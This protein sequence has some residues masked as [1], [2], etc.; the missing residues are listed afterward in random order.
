ME[1]S[2]EAQRVVGPRVFFVQIYIAKRF[3][4]HI[5]TLAREFGNHPM[6]RRAVELKRKVAEVVLRRFRI[7]LPY[8][9]GE[10]YDKDLETCEDVQI[11]INA[12]LAEKERLESK[13]IGE[14]SRGYQLIMSKGVGKPDPKKDA[15][16]E[17]FIA[18][19]VFV[20][21]IAEKARRGTKN[22][23]QAKNMAI[24]MWLKKYEKHRPSVARYEEIP[25]LI[26][27]EKI[28]FEKASEPLI[29]R[30]SFATIKL[31][32]TET[33]A[34][35]RAA[36]D[37]L[38]EETIAKVKK[39]LVETLQLPINALLADYIEELERTP[40]KPKGLVA[41]IAKIR[42][43]GDRDVDV[44]ERK[45]MTQNDLLELF[46]RAEKICEKNLR[47]A[48]EDLAVLGAVFA[49]FMKAGPDQKQIFQKEEAERYCKRSAE[50]IRDYIEKERFLT[51]FK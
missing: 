41:R 2:K 20:G 34:G 36:M 46:S 31:D 9:K 19:H 45:F 25:Q 47:S 37:G 30:A 22:E 3:T 51:F 27:S 7:R 5:K 8:L 26:Q 21:G 11:K 6:G 49:P 1:L 43:N 32:Q 13:G 18:R 12:L 23:E 14:Y 39:G 44:A 35:I 42:M 40:Q 29:W 28:K 24:D 48:D 16:R 4:G 50:E 15:E 33:D 38:N 17:K 10:P